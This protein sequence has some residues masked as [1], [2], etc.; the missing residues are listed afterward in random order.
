[1][2][3]TVA[4]IHPDQPCIEGALSDPALTLEQLR[5]LDKVLWAVRCHDHVVLSEVPPAAAREI[6][7]VVPAVLPEDLGAKQFREAH[8]TRLAY[9]AGAMAGGIASVDLVIALGRMGGL[10]FFGAG[11]VPLPGIED[12]IR[13]IQDALPFEAYGFNLL[14]NAFEPRLELETA[15]LYLKHQVRR[16]DAAAFMVLTPAIV[17]YRARGMRAL[18]DGRVVAP[19]HVF[20]KVS[21]PEVAAQF[22]APPPEALLRELVAAGKLQE[23]EARLAALLPVAEDVTA[24]ADSGGHTDQRPLPVLLPLV[25]QERARAFAAHGYAA[26]GVSIRV[27]A[28]GG[29][30]EPSA[31]HAAFA[32]GA[33]YLMTG[34]I[35]QACLEAGTSPLVKQLLAEADMADVAMAPAPDMFELGA[36]VQVLKRGSLYAQRAQ[37]L[38]DLYKL[39]P[40][41]E[42]IPAAEREKVEKQ[43]LG[44]PFAEVWTDT[45]RYWE[46]RDP[47]K[48]EEGRRDGKA[49]MALCFRW[50]LGMASRWASKGDEARR[51]DYQ[52]W[53]GP[54]IGAFNRWTRGTDLE[55]PEHRDAASVGRALLSGTAALARR[56]AAARAGVV[57]LP[58]AAE[59]ARPGAGPGAPAAR[60]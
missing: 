60:A 2:N 1:M 9:A 7:G 54:A 33:D 25:L 19:N 13:K 52:I 53:C 31:A 12:A 41:F 58:S 43:I 26:R 27:G 48:A 57:P 46:S 47:A 29:I 17:M 39:H 24:E 34:T 44:R 8:G 37:K 5:T 16:V 42:A 38:Y 28:A 59:V 36:R 23:K 35:N 15:E 30:G 21:R 6:A 10:G 11:A 32:L 55:K 40:D 14:H 20:A 45:E 22:F 3:A 56:E 49:R 18:P 4:R 51:W 50:Y